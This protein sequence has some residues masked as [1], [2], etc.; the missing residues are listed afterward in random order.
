M[1]QATNPTPAQAKTEPTQALEQ[2][3]EGLK[4]DPKPIDPNAKTPEAPKK[5]DE[6]ESQRFAA[7]ARKEKAAR[8]AE[9][10]LS[11]KEKTLS[12]REAKAK[13]FEDA[14]TNKDYA[15]AAELLGL[16]YEEWTNYLLND[17]KLTP[18]LEVKSVKQEIEELKKS[19]SEKDNKAEEARKKAAQDEYNQAI[20]EFTKEVNDFLLT[21][22]DEYELIALT[23]TQEVVLAVIEQ[24]FQATSKA[25][26]PKLLSI[27]EASDLVEADLV[28]K[29]SK[30]A[31]T[32]KMQAKSKPQETKK[33]DPKQTTFTQQSRT[34][35]NSMTS[36]S[37][38]SAPART[39]E[40][41]I[42]RAMALLD[43]K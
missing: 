13:A 24:H 40:D 41:R 8:E 4:L 39:E 35:S 33:E 9:A 42:K 1:S 17:K 43:P 30:A 19:L 29:A 20:T 14:K 27:K 22:K 15:K 37:G 32:K 21:N 36:T 5:P 11:A 7:L 23:N 34:L 25:G 28:E 2:K 31:A 38:Q 12:E 3:L 6:K 10:R 16:T 26:E 18:E